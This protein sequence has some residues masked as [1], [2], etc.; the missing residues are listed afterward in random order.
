MSK[1]AFEPAFRLNERSYCLWHWQLYCPT[2][3]T[4]ALYFEDLEDLQRKLFKGT[5]QRSA[6]LLRPPQESS[7]QR[8]ALRNICLSDSSMC[9]S[10]PLVCRNQIYYTSFSK[11]LIYLTL[12]LI[13]FISNKLPFI[14]YV[15]WVSVSPIMHKISAYICFFYEPHIVCLCFDLHVICQICGLIYS[16]FY[17][18]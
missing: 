14:Y 11:W 15:E 6:G 7:S 17:R 3:G 10:P 1:L 13:N 9:C 18:N 8:R 4:S 2:G 5:L 16:T 12:L